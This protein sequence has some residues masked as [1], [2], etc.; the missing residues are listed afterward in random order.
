LLDLIRLRLSVDVLEVEQFGNIGVEVDV[1]TS[2]N[3]GEPKSECFRT[4]DSFCKA[5][6]PGTGQQFLE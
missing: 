4:G 5:N 3:S 2:V 6:I 1:M